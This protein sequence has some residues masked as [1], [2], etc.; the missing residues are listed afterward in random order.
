[1]LEIG[2]LKNFSVGTYQAGVQLAGSLTTYFDNLKVAR[3]I[4]SAEM[5]TGRQVLVAIPQGNP[6]DAVVIAVFTL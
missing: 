3:N 5:I 6:K 4:P 2:V 1:M